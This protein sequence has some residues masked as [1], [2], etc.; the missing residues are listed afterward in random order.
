MMR[1]KAMK[2]VSI[3]GPKSRMDAVVERL[4]ELGVLHIDE[5]GEEE[6]GVDIGSPQEKANALS[7]TLVTLRSVTAKLPDVEGN[8]EQPDV[9]DVGDAVERVNTQLDEIE[10]EMEEVKASRERKRATIEKLRTLQRMKVSPEA[11]HPY[12]SVD[13]HFGTVE[14]HGYEDALEEGRY[15]LYRDGDTIA[16]FVDDATDMESALRDAGF[17]PIPVE[18]LYDVDAKPGD[19]IADLEESISMLDDEL[20]RLRTEKEDLAREWKPFFEET[21]D[22]LAAELERAEAPL[23]FATTDDTFVAEGW[24]P[25]ED[26]DQVVE[27]LEQVTGGRI[28]IDA[29]DAEH[30]APVEHDNPE[31]V[32]RFESLIGLYGT[33]SYGEIDPTFLLL[34]FPLLFGF[35]L[36]DIGY[37]LTTLAVFWLFAKKFPDA[38]A[39]WQSLMFASIATILFGLA[40]AE[41]FGF[42]IFGHSGILGAG[43]NDL[44]AVTG[45]TLFEHVPVLFHR[46]HELGTVLEISVLIGVIHVNAGFLIGAYN[47]Y[48]HHGLLE[49]FYAKGSW[50]VIEVGAALWYLMGT[51]VGAPVLLAGVVLLFRGEG[52][53]GV[54]ELPSLLSNILSYLRVFGVSIAVVSLALVV[55]RMA[56]PLFQSGS[57]LYIALGVLILVVGHVLN[58]FIKLMEAG[59]QG[60]R[61]HYVEFFTKFFEG[62]GTY[63][64]P[65]GAKRYQHT[66]TG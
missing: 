64:K 42:T 51:A 16:L 5:Y 52:I 59:L 31:G 33:P 3:L 18:D 57:V 19:A 24:I 41:M 45:I 65:F 40:Y 1:P 56:A 10:D 62:G 47:E 46:A 14:S 43:T 13:I 4:H 7:D 6:Q 8:G 66:P 15:E 60:I 44:T 26:F 32:D 11:F 30:E 48:L 12:E 27:E 54:V 39:L 34:T 21:A 58:T 61:L 37:G 55:N 29:E 38:K 50:I 49:A 17:D 35:M 2:R 63:Y 28:H 53:E 20:E 22:E 9:D 23:S 36:G 25:A